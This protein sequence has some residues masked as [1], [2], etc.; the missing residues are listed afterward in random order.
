MNKQPDRDKN[1]MYDMWGT[2]KLV[3][4][5]GSIDELESSKVKFHQAKMLYHDSA[6]KDGLIT[7]LFVV[8]LN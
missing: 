4:D 2:D 5:Y 1:F 6:G 3:T 8:V 7:F